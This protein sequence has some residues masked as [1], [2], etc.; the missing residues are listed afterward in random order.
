[1]VGRALLRRCP[2]CGGKKAWFLG[3][4]RKAE[5]CPSCGLRWSRGQDGW[6][7][8]AMTVAVVITGGAVMTLLIVGII[9]SYPDIAVV[10]MTIIGVGL[11]V[12]VPILTYPFTHTLFSAFDLAVHEMAPAEIEAAK[13]YTDGLAAGTN[14]RSR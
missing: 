6:E 11:A 13:A 2:W 7:L 5:R 9:V 3:W 4:F 8:G 10:P 14:N 1:M 12:V